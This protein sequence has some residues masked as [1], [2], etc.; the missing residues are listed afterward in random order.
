MTT[1]KP[2]C[3]TRPTSEAAPFIA[4]LPY[5]VQST[6]EAR[7][8]VAENPRSFL[9]IDEPVVNFPRGTDAYDLPVYLKA[10]ALL[11][12]LE[13]AGD[14]TCD[15]TPSYY[16]YELTWQ[17][18]VQN[19]FVACVA[20]DDYLNGIVKEHESTR[21]NKEMDRINHIRGCE[22]QTGPIFLTYHFDQK[23]ANLLT[24]IKRSKPLFDFEA[25]DGVRHRGFLIPLELN[26]LITTRFN[27]IGRVYIADGHHRV[28]AA[29]EVAK[30]RRLAR[31]SNEPTEQSDYFLAVLF[32]DTELHLLPYNRVVHNLNDLS[33]EEFLDELKARF[34]VEPL[35]K[36]NSNAKDPLPIT[37]L[38]A[39]DEQEAEQALQA[40][41]PTEKGEFSVLLNGIW[42]RCRIRAC[43]QSS[44]P[45]EGLDVS[46]LQRR[47][48]EP[49]LGIADPRRSPRIDFVG[50]ARGLKELEYRCQTD[51]A[52]AFALYP[53][54]LSEFFTI[55]D[56][57]LLMPPKSTWFEPK[58]RSGL[59]IHKI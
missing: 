16:L 55:A 31:E 3:A 23:L 30:A 59:F 48:F 17:G 25:N 12:E 49:V 53:T 9:A 35:Y 28:A 20:I 37:I 45:S 26:E 24:E 34:E 29:S 54:T 4:A 13:Q 14:M 39:A 33:S 52:A 7:A 18:Q 19:G 1:I 42:Y 22:A 6:E 47:L 40:V 5:D 27:Q 44:D 36:T 32:A 15:T 2:F 50:G 8:I 58:L 38:N 46:I 51:C 11:K 43:D 56:A 41:S 10:G 57:G 21:V